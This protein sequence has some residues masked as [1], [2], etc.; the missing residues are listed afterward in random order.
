MKRLKLIVDWLENLIHFAKSKLSKRQ[1]I[2]FSSIIVGASSATAAI[3]LKLFVH[4]IFEFAT[5]NRISNLK[6]FY[7]LLPMIGILLT[8]FVIQKVLGGKLDK[9]LAQIHASIAK[10]SSFLPRKNMFDQLLT[11]SLTVGFGG[12]TGLEAPIVIT[13]AAFGSN[14]SKTYKLNYSERT[15]LLACGISAGIAAAFNAPIA[16]VLFAL[17]VLLVDISISAFTPLIIASATGALISIITIKKEIL[18]NFKLTQEFNFWNVPF[19]VL[20]GI[21]AGLIAVYHARAFL[22]IEHTLSKK[23]KKPIVR[24]LITGVLLAGLIAIFPPLF[25]EG[26]QSIKMLADNSPN[27]LFNN[28]IIQF[29]STN[30]LIVLCF[31]GLLVFLKSVATALTIG[32]GGNGG[33]FAPSLF[34]GAYLG[35]FISRFVNYFKLTELPENNFTLVGMAG[36]LSGLYHAPLTSIFLIAEITG[37]YSLMVPLMIVSSISFAVSK[38]FEPFSMDAKKLAKKGETF[39]TDKDFNVLTTIKTSEF[40]EKDYPQISPFNSLRNL[41]EIVSHSKRNIFPVTSNEGHLL[42]IVLL[43]DIREIMFKI[44]AYDIVEVKELMRL[45]LAVVQYEDNMNQVMKY[46]DETGA[47]ILP[48]VRN[49]QFEGFVSKSNVFSGYRDKLKHH[50]IE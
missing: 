22:K 39:T 41:V 33:N 2:L 20:L 19:Y 17:E 8:V 21:L 25:G 47:W 42:G 35:F 13:G 16:G 3:L 31:V 36:I 29:L 15:L 46:F 49:L 34:I 12:S 28:S 6:F 40:I 10:K 18:L 14:Y 11:S 4:I 30:E 24:I 44:D 5:H 45:P 37:G 7:L 9:G 23:I 27:Q 50:T 1:F 43:D 38:Y 26:Y 48:V 32:G